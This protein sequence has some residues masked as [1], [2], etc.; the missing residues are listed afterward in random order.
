MK[1]V[2]ILLACILMCGCT[3][4]DA[5]K[6]VLSIVETTSQTRYTQNSKYILSNTHED[7]KVYMDN[8]L[9]SADF[10]D[11]VRATITTY[12]KGDEIEG[13][14]PYHFSVSCISPDLEYVSLVTLKISGNKI[15]DLSVL[16][17][18]EYE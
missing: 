10:S 12:H 17:G 4:I 18:T 9:K 13:V 3:T 15:I 1:K 14:V 5:S 6:L 2:I 7:Y 16:T 8:Y 11:E